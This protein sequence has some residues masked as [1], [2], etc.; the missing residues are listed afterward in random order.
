[1][2][3][4]IGRT[5]VVLA[6]RWL[7]LERLATLTLRRDAYADTPGPTVGLALGERTHYRAAAWLLDTFERAALGDAYDVDGL[8][9]VNGRVEPE[10][11]GGGIGSALHTRTLPRDAWAA[12]VIGALAGDA[13]V[14]VLIRTVDEP[15]AGY[16]IRATPTAT[17]IDRLDAGGWTTLTSIPTPWRPGETLRVVFEWDR[18]RVY[19]DAI[20]VADVHDAGPHLAGRAGFVA[21]RGD[22]AADAAITSFLAGDARQEYLGAGLDLGDVQRVIGQP[23]SFD[24][25]LS[26]LAPMGG[27]D[28]F[29]ALLRH[30]RNDGPGTYDLDRGDVRVLTVVD[31]APAPLT[32]GV[33]LIESPAEVTED[34]VKLIVRGRDAFL[35]PK[36]EPGTVAYLPGP[37]P[38]GLLPLPSDPCAASA[39]PGIIV[40]PVPPEPV[41]PPDGG[42][43]DPGDPGGDGIG[44]EAPPVPPPDGGDAA[45]VSYGKA[46]TAYTGHIAKPGN[47][48]VTDSETDGPIERPPILTGTNGLITT[49]RKDAGIINSGSDTFHGRTARL[50]VRRSTPTNGT[51]IRFTISGGYSG[52]PYAGFVGL[53][54]FR[55][56]HA[57][58]IEAA[59][60][61]YSDIQKAFAAPPPAAPVAD[62]GAISNASGWLPV[63]GSGGTPADFGPLVVELSVGDLTI[64]VFTADVSEGTPVNTEVEGTLTARIE[65]VVFFTP[66]PH[67]P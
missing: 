8:V 67:T 20:C 66:P 56:D 41:D 1:M 24:L 44:P 30:G 12:V 52:H 46:F 61:H 53:G 62:L 33:G 15:A 19:R 22:D 58:R 39:P 14:G 35:T 10:I 25:T 11:V 36:I 2:R 18:C 38:G 6:R 48:P 43:G 16:R 59:W 13:S 9:L 28:R 60:S 7:R 64:F 54:G 65:S 5:P 45:I 32:S 55:E 23:A 37:P 27:K 42:P 34:R 21:R 3:P 29:A 26:N 4:L 57:D 47:N 51:H 40:G 17:L 31:G 50:Y 49:N 63:G